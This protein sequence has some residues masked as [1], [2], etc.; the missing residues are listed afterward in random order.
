MILL[1]VIKEVVMAKNKS[2]I[3]NEGIEGNLFKALIRA[4]TP[5]KLSII[6][7]VISNLLV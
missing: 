3:N 7:L 2:I 5:S 6:G 1:E 4:I